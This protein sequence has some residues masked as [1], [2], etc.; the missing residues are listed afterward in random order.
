MKS[1]HPTFNLFLEL[2]L[3]DNGEI[4][5]ISETTPSREHLYSWIRWPLPRQVMYQ[6]L[7]SVD[8]ALAVLRANRPAAV[9][10]FEHKPQYAL[11]LYMACLTRRVPVF[12]FSHGLQQ[13]QSRS[14]AHRLGFKLLRALVTHTAFWAIQLELAD[15]MLPKVLRYHKSLVLPLP[16]PKAVGQREPFDPRR[17]RIGIAGILRPDKPVL[18]LLALLQQAFR[19]DTNFELSLGTPFWQLSDAIRQSGVRLVDTSRPEQ[20]QEHL[21]NCDIVVADFD[22]ASFYFRPSAIIND[23]L[24]AGCYVLAPDY[25][26]FRAQLNQPCTVGACFTNQLEIPNYIRRA[27]SELEAGKVDF[28]SWRAARR[29][30]LLL[31]TLGQAIDAARQRK[32]FRVAS[33]G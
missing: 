29:D 16:L 3:A 1:A 9:L 10:I 12:F 17:V 25:P 20:F 22:E 6:S 19:E 2:R 21:R 26:V 7:K 15:D 5:F 24:S 13:L 33:N 18:P 4:A 28:V 31:S 14:T 27:V 30:E 8:M 32:D 23:A 11:A